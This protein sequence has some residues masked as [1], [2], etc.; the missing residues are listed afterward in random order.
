MEKTPE[1]I[2]V[3][4]LCC[5]S[6][7]YNG[8]GYTMILGIEAS[9]EVSSVA[10]C[11]EEGLRSEYT[12]CRKVTHSEQLLP[13]VHRVLD[14]AEVTWEGIRAVAV[15]VGPGSFTGLRVAV[16]TAKGLAYAAKK[17]VVPVSSLLGLAHRFA[18]TQLPICVL[19]DARKGEVYTAL[20]RSRE[21]VVH[22]ISPERAV[23][24]EK[25]CEEI[26]ETTLFVGEG[27]LKYR[28]LLE[29]R[30][31][32]YTVIVPGSINLLSAASIGEIG[33]QKVNAGQIIDPAEL[34]PNY[35]RRS[36][37]EMNLKSEP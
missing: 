25:L 9:T 35:I 15:S 32:S 37:A 19:L 31:P 1:F 7:V 11:G 6:N 34:V 24:P 16:S 17:P 33:L 12:L 30:I 8:K 18:A 36:E 27:A 28:S 26:R 23:S 10:L 2:G 5:K 21:G 3:L 22:R 14:D 29:E 4:L 13:V 20:F